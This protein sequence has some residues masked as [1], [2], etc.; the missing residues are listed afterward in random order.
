[1]CSSYSRLKKIKKLLLE[2]L[3]YK[4][5]NVP[6]IDHDS[7]LSSNKQSINKHTFPNQKDQA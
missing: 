1:M 5:S 6:Q 7:P 2:I 4:Q 3:I